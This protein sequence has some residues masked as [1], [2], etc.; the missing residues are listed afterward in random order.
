[1]VEQNFWELLEEKKPT[2]TKTA[3]TVADY[4]MEHSEDAQYLSISSM[5]EKCGV[6]E[7]TIYRFCRQ[8]GFNGYNE[9]KISLAQAHVAQ[10]SHSTLSLTT[11]MSTAELIEHSVGSFQSVISDTASVLSADAIDQAALLLKHA[12][13]VYCFGQGGSMVLAND[14]WVRFSTISNKF[15]I[16]LDSHMQL[17]A[18]SL[19]TSEDVVIFISYSGATH[20]MMHILSEVKKSGAKIILITHHADAP[21]TTLADVV[22]LCGGH[23]S[24]VELGSIPIKAGVLFVADVLV[25]RYTLDNYDLAKASRKRSSNATA[26][27]FL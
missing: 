10:P 16:S 26:V 22:L 25:L 7:A 18:A 1:M 4:L 24:P 15:R 21:G 13:S 27:K 19:M 23:E 12:K 17:I 11:E 8:L 9:M 5:A 14:I 6:A 20:D 3:L 2:L